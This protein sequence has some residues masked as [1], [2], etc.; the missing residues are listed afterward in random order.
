MDHQKLQAVFLDRDGTL[1]GSDQMILPGEFVCYPSVRESIVALKAANK[2]I[3]SFTN[4]PVIARG[5]AK[6]EQFEQELKSFGFDGVYVCPHEY[7]EGCECR[8]PSAGML[9][10]AAEENE[11]DLRRCVVIGDRWT[12][13]VAAKEAGCIG[14]LVRT[15][16][17][18]TELNKYERGEF[19]E[20]WEK[21]YPDCV[22][23]D[24][25]EAIRWI[26][27]KDQEEPQMTNT[28][29]DWPVWAT[30]EIEIKAADPSWLEKGAEEAARLKKL[31]ADYRVNDIE[32]IGSTSI[33][34]LPAKPILD[35]MARIPSYGELEAIIT[36]LAAHDW[37]YVPPELDG[38]PSRRFFVKVK[39]DK[40]Q[41]H[42]HLMLQNEE[43]WDKQL[44]F[45]DILRLRP[46]RVQEYAEL[47]SKLAEHYKNDREA[48][49]RA[50]TDFVQRVLSE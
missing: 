39:N 20:R 14:I 30:E 46:E 7:G 25:N 34:G 21:A 1:G 17:G 26:L 16:A 37:H 12:D 18:Q 43:K 11:L 8:K 41:C 22:A 42:L 49:T 50:K 28:N 4:Q 23:E 44:R 6:L 24:L 32:H 3:Y 2:R 45:R 10:R 27:E 5:Q 40:R 36:E 33:P 15:G 13:M 9:M 47:K 48:Y 29:P 19:S 35:V 31:L 38:V